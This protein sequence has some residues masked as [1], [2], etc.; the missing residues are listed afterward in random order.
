[1]KY[2][3]EPFG[4]RKRAGSGGK[5]MQGSRPGALLLSEGSR[6]GAG[7]TDAN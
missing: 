3:A 7:V 2:R 4:W 5:K 1:M 6:R